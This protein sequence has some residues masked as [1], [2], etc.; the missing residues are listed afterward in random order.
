M[1][2]LCLAR[3]VATFLTFNFSFISYATI[4]KT[5]IVDGDCGE[6]SNLGAQSVIL[7]RDVVL[8]IFQNEERCGCVMGSQTGASVLWT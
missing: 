7:S 1:N 8:Q 5:P 2:R 4:A 3:I 6:Y